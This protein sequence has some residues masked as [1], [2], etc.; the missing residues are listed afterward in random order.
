MVGRQNV[1]VLIR[2][3][4]RFGF[5]FGSFAVHIVYTHQ[6][7]NRPGFLT[8]PCI[9]LLLGWRSGPVL[10]FRA[11]T[12]GFGV[13]RTGLS[14]PVVSREGFRLACGR[15]TPHGHP[16][17]Y[18]R[19]ASPPEQRPR[20]LG[21]RV[22]CL[23]EVALKVAKGKLGRI[24][25]DAVEDVAMETLEALAEKVRE[26]KSADELKPMTASIAHNLAVTCLREHFAQKRGAGRTQSLDAVN[27]EG[28]RLEDPAA[29]ESPLNSLEQAELSGLLGSLLRQ[30][31]P[32][33]SGII[34]DF[35][36]RGI[37]YQELA[38]KHARPIGSIGVMM[39]RGLAAIR[40]TAAR[41]PVVLKELQA[42]MRG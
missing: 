26:M 32:E 24:L 12:G 2:S 15:C 16:R 23:G 40:E 4:G 6:I 29:P 19:L 21:L 10:L 36:L 14:D 25:P 35:H 42:Y 37:N 41:Y 7:A 28:E 30:L 13:Q 5:L 39:K 31:K 33:V 17:G 38:V 8:S 20:R 9:F 22:Y 3:L 27:T 11:Q 34:G 18:S 1:A